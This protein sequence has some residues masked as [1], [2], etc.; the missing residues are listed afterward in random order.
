[1]DFEAEFEDYLAMLS[2]RL[3]HADRVEPFGDYCR[4]LML[5]GE[6]KSVEPMAARV[7][8][9]RV[10]S[11][12]QSLHHFVAEASWSDAGLLDAVRDYVVP[13]LRKGEGRWS[14]IV[15]DTGFPKKGRHSVGVGRQYCGQLGKQDNCQVAVS[16][17]LANASGSLPIA[18]RLYLPKEWAEDAE[19]RQK[20]G[21]PEEVVFATKGEIALLQIEQALAAGVPRA[22]VLADAAYG[23]ESAFREQLQRWGLRYCVAVH[24]TTS[25]WAPGHQGLPPEPYG[26]R[27][28]PPKRLRVSQTH[29]PLSVV[30][31]ASALAP[32]AWRQLSWREGT[33]SPLSGR[34]AVL[35]VRP[36]HRDTKRSEPQPEC[37]LLIE[38]PKQQT[39][40]IKYWL[41][42]LAPNT[43][44]RELITLAKQ[45]WRIERDYQELKQELGLGH[46]EGRG[47]RGFH[48]HASLCI[49]AYGF[50]M[51]QRLLTEGRA[52]KNFI[53]RLK[54]PPLPRGFRP[55]GS[56]AR[57][58]S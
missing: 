48:H 11:K 22:V 45:R 5:P 41:S 18:Y 33:N 39:E 3:G 31:L 15:D 52:K 58:A 55:R 32:S 37:W 19:R 7:A 6:R 23:N 30:A 8:P 17:S 28:R 26:G 38:W 10:R 54:A 2:G 12:H 47:W 13:V 21:V 43:P 57:S 44:K 42:N 25:V 14:W 46:Y 35:R 50:L 36:A 56:P 40:P 9:R 16:V 29:K 49:A 4:G 51:V 34:F 27:G 53:V 1:M 24:S 20:A